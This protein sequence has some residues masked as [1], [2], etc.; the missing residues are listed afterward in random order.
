MTLLLPCIY[1]NLSVGATKLIIATPQHLIS[2]NK[3]RGYFI[4]KTRCLICGNH[5]E[6]VTKD[7]LENSRKEDSDEKE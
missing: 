3:E 6:F 7:E 4:Y 2:K 1:C 5:N